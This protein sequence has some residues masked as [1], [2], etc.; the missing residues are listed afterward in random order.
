MSRAWIPGQVVLL[1]VLTGLV[2]VSSM[3]AVG[4][5][6]VDHKHPV[7]RSA[8]DATL[9]GERLN[10]SATDG[11]SP[12]SNAG[13]T[14]SR[15]N[16]ANTNHINTTGPTNPITTRWTFAPE[17]DDVAAGPVVVNGTVYF[18]TKYVGGSETNTG[19]LYAVDAWTG[20]KRWTFQSRSRKHPVSI[21][22]LRNTVYVSTTHG[23][24]HALNAATGEKYWTF[25]ADGRPGLTVADRTLFV[26]TGGS[27][28]AL[29]ALRGEEKWVFKTDGG[30]IGNPAV[31]DGTVYVG[32]R[33][34]NVTALDAETGG[35][36]WDIDVNETSEQWLNQAAVANG[37]VYVGSKVLNALPSTHGRLYALDA[38]TGDVRWKRVKQGNSIPTPAVLPN[39]VYFSD[40]YLHAADSQTGTD[41]WSKR[42]IKGT[43]V[44]LNNIGYIS[45]GRTLY[46]LDPE[47]GAHQE[48]FTPPPF[49]NSWDR[50]R[51]MAVLNGSL[52]TGVTVDDPGNGY[53]A[54][55]AILYALGTPEFTYS[56]LTVTPRS[57]ELNE[58]VTVTAT[59]TNTGTGP[60][61]YNASLAVNGNVVNSSSGGLDAGM[62][63]TITY[64]L[65]F[66]EK[67]SYTIGIGGRTQSIG[68][69]GAT[70]APTPTPTEP[71]GTTSDGRDGTPVSGSDGTPTGT[72][73]PEPTPGFG[74]GHW[75]VAVA[76]LAGLV[77]LRT[78]D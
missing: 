37:N 17:E 5:P 60:G 56:N 71:Q 41:R 23:R 4:S 16:A 47:G 3:A 59:V 50:F 52:Y 36:N 18:G 22:V 75:I 25:R 70:P 46:T 42:D 61:R 49:N 53:R 72:P 32:T 57:P 7:M 31:K 20:E 68:V 28:Y 73:T 74:V 24:V 26:N 40:D 10:S 58:S 33:Y 39:T 77:R 65:S 78:R 12:P 21:A 44:L 66:S 54:D 13:W 55:R 67:G 19:K 11:S 63:Q 8:S 14:M 62:S 34:G 9:P 48:R 30:P 64:R 2:I 6:A 27:V 1:L 51:G 38:E 29:E 45:T 15:A 76:V 69:G 35:V 43:P